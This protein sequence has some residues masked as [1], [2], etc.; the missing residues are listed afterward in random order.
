MQRTD[1][2][3]VPA[4]APTGGTAP[5]QPPLRVAGA[6]LSDVL[7][8]R[9]SEAPLPNAAAAPDATAT[10][11]TRGSQWRAAVARRGASRAT[12]EA[13]QRD[14]STEPHHD[15]GPTLGD[16]AMK[17]A[18]AG[19]LGGVALLLAERLTS[20]AV[21]P[22]GERVHEGR[23]AAEAIADTRDA[24]L[25][26]AQAEAA[27]AGLELGACALLGAVYGM[28]QSRLHPPDVL[29]GLLLGGVSW[30]ATNSG[31]GALPRLGAAA[32]ASMQSME[33][34]AVPVASHVA[35]GVATAMAF[36]ALG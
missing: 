17:G 7:T 30:M 2:T 15:A 31:A 20:R 1:T 25:S 16:A 22:P 36:D 4:G 29:H 33:R 9:A 5:L 6:G 14:A 27:G 12:P 34:T 35:Y 28:V 10:S 24:A 23:D 13:Q 21:L 8:P 32:P 11:A 3:N 19:M 18:V 26:P